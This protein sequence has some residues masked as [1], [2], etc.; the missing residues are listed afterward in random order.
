MGAARARGLLA[1][2]LV[3]S[4]LAGLFKICDNDVWWHVRTGEII[5]DTARVPRTDPFSHLAEGHA[6]ITHEWL[7]EAVAA[8][9]ARAGGL[10]A[11]TL[12]KCGV[13]AFLALVLWR[14]ARGAGASAGAAFAAILLAIATAR[15][16]F[17][18]RPHLATLVLLPVIL[19]ALARIVA[20]P[21]GGLSRR[22]LAVPLLFLLWAN[23]HGGFVIGL[24]MFPVVG[25]AGAA[26][27]W[28]VRRGGGAPGFARLRRLGALF[29]LSAA[30]TLANPNGIHAHLYPLINERAL[31]VVR[32]GEW[33]PPELAQFPL[34]FTLLVATALLA[35]AFGRAAGAARLAPLAPL[36]ALALRSNRSIGELAVVAAVPLALLVD[37]ACAAARVRWGA[38]AV[39]LA[40]AAPLAL[41]AT[42]IALDAL[43]LTINST[44]YRFGLGVNEKCFPIRAADFVA[45]RGLAGRLANSP[46]FGG[47]LIWR[48]WPERKVF[49]DGRLDV[50]VDANERLARTPWDV[51]LRERAL[52]YGILMTE[53]PVG[54]DAM[55]S[56]VAAS[57]EWSLLFWDD[58]AMV[59]ATRAAGPPGAPAA[60]SAERYVVATPLRDPTAIPPESLA[61]ARAEYERA[62]REPLRFHAL[63]GLGAVLIRERDWAGAA[64]AL[65]AALALRPRDAGAWSNLSLAYLE[66][67]HASDALAAARRAVRLSR[68]SALALRHLGVALFDL[69]RVRE[70]EDAF[71]RVAALLPGNAEIAERLRACREAAADPRRGG[72]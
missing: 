71:R 9:V 29:A 11:L 56:A 1:L 58:V 60:E 46:P 32:N 18:E 23:L 27:A 67:G 22:D 55:T 2:L 44:F 17:F 5:L 19:D 15:F 30:S 35:L 54:R 52:A 31:R 13:A 37:G 48:F 20:R 42:L 33:L 25:L 34:F 14:L 4:F 47:Y 61:V 38:R 10:A 53:S 6:W 12:A 21:G 51:T 65:E 45:S 7:A 40:R 69:G 39:P 3:L 68:G 64:R 72:R 43:G 63:F 70:A 49:A 8:A 62:S 24:A 26:A 59:W 66:S 41:A 36:A 50:Y 28:R 57:A 16:R